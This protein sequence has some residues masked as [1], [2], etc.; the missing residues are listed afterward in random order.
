MLYKA[1]F[2][3]SKIAKSSACSRTKTTAILNEAMMPEIQDYVKKIMKTD[4]YAL[5]NDGSNGQSL[6]KMNAFRAV[7]F[8]VNWSKRVG[9]RDSYTQITKEF[10]D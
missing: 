10:R 4:T 2:L 3:D 6:K 1:M 9:W 5:M 7:I 8:D